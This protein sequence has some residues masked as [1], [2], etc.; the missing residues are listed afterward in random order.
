MEKLP[1]NVSFRSEA[2][3]DLKKLDGSI[4]KKLIKQIIKVSK[5]LNPKAKEDTEYH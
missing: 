2:I 4:K 1:E 3:S 5:N